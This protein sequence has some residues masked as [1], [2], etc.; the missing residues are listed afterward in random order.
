MSFPVS[1]KYFMKRCFPAADTFVEEFAAF[2]ISTILFWIMF[3]YLVFIPCREETDWIRMMEG[4][5]SLFG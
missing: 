3:N 4:E 1:C 2:V 5:L